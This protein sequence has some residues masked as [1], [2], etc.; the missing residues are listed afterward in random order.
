[1]KRRDE[2]IVGA[3]I[4]VTVVVVIAGAFWLSQTRL[5]A[6]AAVHNARFQTV[7]GLGVGSPVV[8]RGVRVGR[9]QAI[10]L[11]ER[12]WVEAEVQVY[13]GVVLP[14][15][16]AVVAASRS[17]FGEWQADIISLDQAPDDPNV[18]RDL[19]AALAEGDDAWPG[20]TLPDIGQLTAQANR[21]ATDIT[22]ISSRIQTVFDSQAVGELQGAIRN[23]TAIADN[24]NRFTQ[25]QTDIMGDVGSNLRQ[26]SDVLADA[27][28]RLQ[29]S[30]ARVDEATEQG[31]LEMILDNTAAASE[32]VRNALEDLREVVAVARANQASL[33]R[34]IQGADTLMTR[35]QEGTGTLGLLMSD[36]VLYQEARLAVAQLREL[37]ADIQAN[38]RKYFKFSVF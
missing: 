21:I 27:A 25:Q 33:V 7:G 19:E 34:L 3:T 2:I 10:R 22:T 16:P 8:L 31:E 29:T 4:L 36:S 38:P 13:E 26:G 1:M 14:A 32:Q 12:N 18:R 20:A 37:L 6:S 11:G 9:V 15:R 17:L 35:L 24:I 28:Q 23:F 30:L 5:G